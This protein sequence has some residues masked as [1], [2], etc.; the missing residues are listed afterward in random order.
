MRR[1]GNHS[2]GDLTTCLSPLD[3]E[4]VH[5]RIQSG[6]L[7]LKDPSMCLCSNLE[8]TLRTPQESLGER[9]SF[10]LWRVV[11]LLIPEYYYHSHSGRANSV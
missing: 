9:R 1:F 10:A 8:T 2:Q 6:D 7:S 3:E 11:V 5:E 4:A